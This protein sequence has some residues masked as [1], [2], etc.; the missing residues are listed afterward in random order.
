MLML[1]TW[2]G[3][4]TVNGMDAVFPFVVVAVMVVVPFPTIETRPD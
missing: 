2:T 4:D 1:T 3:N